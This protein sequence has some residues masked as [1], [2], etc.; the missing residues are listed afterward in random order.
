MLQRGGKSGML[1]TAAHSG[2]CREE[3][4][5]HCST[6]AY[7]QSNIAL[8]RNAGPGKSGLAHT[9]RSRPQRMAKIDNPPPDETSRLHVREHIN[10]MVEFRGIAAA[11]ARKEH[12]N[13]IICAVACK[14]QHTG[15]MMLQRHGNSGVQV[16]GARSGACEQNNDTAACKLQ[17]TGDIMLQRHGNSGIQSQR[18]A[19]EHAN[20]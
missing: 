18:P 19:A 3:N 20:K 17:H 4:N 2:A 7:W 5:G 8:E 10:G 1:I 13:E 16:A 15:E 14:L 9:P 12:A 6:A 11:A